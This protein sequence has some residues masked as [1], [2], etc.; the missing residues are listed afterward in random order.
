M[1]NDLPFFDFDAAVYA[2]KSH[3]LHFD[4]GLMMHYWRKL[5]DAF[6]TLPKLGSTNL[7]P[8]ILPEYKGTGG[9]NLAILEGRSDWG[10]SAH[11]VGGEIDTS[12]II[13]FD[14]FPISKD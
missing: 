10:V 3:K 1:K 14:K 9:C 11:Y 2:I 7:H 12:E 8:A 13:D 5:R 4:I 6:L